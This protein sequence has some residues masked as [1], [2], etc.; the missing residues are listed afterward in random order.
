MGFYV[1]MAVLAIG[2]IAYFGVTA[3]KAFRVGNRYTAGKM[4]RWLIVFLT[5]IS[6][7]MA[8]RCFFTTV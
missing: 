6:A 7:V 8:A 2:V 1:V 5:A 3:I 4:V